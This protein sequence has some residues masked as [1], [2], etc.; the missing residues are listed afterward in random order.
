M[1]EVTCRAWYLKAALYFGRSE[2]SVVVSIKSWGRGRCAGRQ[3]LCAQKKNPSEHLLV[4]G[5]RRGL[6]LVGG[7]EAEEHGSVLF[8][9][10]VGWS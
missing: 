3:K 1:Q 6:A 7:E 4:K 10:A 8:A 5:L 9:H 2:L